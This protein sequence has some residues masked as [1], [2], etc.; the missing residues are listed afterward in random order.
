MGSAFTSWDYPQK[1]LLWRKCTPMK[2]GISVEIE[3]DWIFSSEFTRYFIAGG[4][5]IAL[6]AGRF[7]LINDLTSY[8]KISL[9]LNNFACL[10]NLI[11]IEH[12]IFTIDTCKL[13]IIKK[14]YGRILVKI[15]RFKFARNL[16]V[17]WRILYSY[18]II[19]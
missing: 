1:F 16:E 18:F 3:S 19:W 14:K 6:S 17:V 11:P 5:G 2:I 7:W 4:W 12:F 8:C 13:D 9:S 15:D 10:N